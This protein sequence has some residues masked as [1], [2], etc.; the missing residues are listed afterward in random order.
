MTPAK[1]HTCI[2]VV[3]LCKP[4]AD[5]LQLYSSILQYHSTKSDAFDT[6][7]MHNCPHVL[8]ANRCSIQ[9]E[10]LHCKRSGNETGD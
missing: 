4:L 8:P 10:A 5:V 6:M 7:P 3:G 9:E 1:H 2:F